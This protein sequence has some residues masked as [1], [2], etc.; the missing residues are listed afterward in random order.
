MEVQRVCR[1]CRRTIADAKV[2]RCCSTISKGVWKLKVLHQDFDRGPKMGGSME[3]RLDTASVA[4]TN[5]KAT[6]RQAMETMES[7]TA[8]ED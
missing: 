4:Q 5:C 8:I 6:R 1:G 2:S 7:I 3:S